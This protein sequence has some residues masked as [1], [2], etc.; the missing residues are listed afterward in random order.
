MQKIFIQEFGIVL[1]H[2]Q[3]DILLLHP[4]IQNK[5]FGFRSVVKKQDKNIHCE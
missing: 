1:P 5:G 2:I 4:R 3:E